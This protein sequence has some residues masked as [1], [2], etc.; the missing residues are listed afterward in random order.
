MGICQG[1]SNQYVKP[2]L[3][4]EALARLSRP[5]IEIVE[6]VPRKLIGLHHIPASSIAHHR[7]AGA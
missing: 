1:S 6:L 2:Q 3:I 4:P 7:L 5:A